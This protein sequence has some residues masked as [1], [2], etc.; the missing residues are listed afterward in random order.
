MLLLA[1]LLFAQAVLAVEM[2]APPPE[3]LRLQ[4]QA[5]PKFQFAGYYAAR[6]QG[7]Y[8]EEGLDVEIQPR[9]SGQDVLQQVMSGQADFGIGDAGLVAHAANGQPLTLVA[10]V[11][12]H[13][14]QALFSKRSLAISAPNAILGK[15]IMFDA[16]SNDF[17]P[18]RMLFS[19]LKMQPEQ[20]QSVLGGSIDELLRGKSDLIV[21]NSTE[22]PHEFKKR[23]IA[24]NSIQPLDYGIDVY[25]E[26]LF[27]SLQQIQAHPER[28]ERFRRAS[29]KGWHYALEHSE[30]LVRLL[31]QQYHSD[32][33]MKALR[34]EAEVMRRLMLPEQ[35]PLGHLDS[36]RVKAIAEQ[37]QTLNMAPALS[38]SQ[39]QQLVYYPR[40]PQ[41]PSGDQPRQA[42]PSAQPSWIGT[43]PAKILD[44]AEFVVIAMVIF[45]LFGYWIYRLHR[46]VVA[47]RLSEAELALLYTNM[48]L[49]F[50]LHQVQR[51][52]T[53]NIVDYF[54]LQINPAFEAMTG[55]SRENVCGKSARQLQANS[56]SH[57]LKHFADVEA[58]G[59]AK[60]FESHAQASNRW[61]ITD[62]YQAGK[63]RFVVLLH[64]IS[65]RKYAEQKLQLS[66]RVFSD[67]HEGIIIT[68]VH[69]GI[70]DVNAAFSSIT[71]YSRE[72]VLG[73]NPGL[74]KSGRHDNDFYQA[75]WADLLDHGHWQGEVWNRRKN[76]EHFVELLTISALR[77]DSEQVINYLGI[78]SD[79]TESKKQQQRLEQLA[80]YD[81]LTQLPNRAL[82]ADRFNQAIANSRR[83]DEL[84]AVCYLDLDGFKR[85]NDSFGHEVGDELLIEVAKRIKLKLRESDTVC[86]LGGDEFVMLLE[87]LQS[88]QQ[89]EETLKRI[90]AALAEVFIA[91]SKEIYISASSGVTLYPLDKDEPDI[92]LRHAD[93][94]M[95][96][97]KQAGRNCYRFHHYPSFGHSYSKSSNVVRPE[98]EGDEI[99]LALQYE[100][101]CL[102]YQPKVNLKTGEVIGVEALIRWQHPQRG[103]L[104]PGEFLPQLESTTLELDI[105]NWLVRQAFQQLQNWLNQGVKLQ[106]SI[107]VSPRFLQWQNFLPMLDSVLNEYPD[108]SSRQI[109]LEVLESSVL[110]DM[111]S[112]A[113]VLR[114][115]Y[116]QFGVSS[117]LDDFGTGYSSL[118]HLRHLTINTVKIDQ[119]FVRNMID[120]PDDQS[121][122][123]SVIGLAKAFKREVI[124]EG[125]ESLDDGIFL[126]NLGCS[127]AQGNIIAPPM[128]GSQVLDWVRDYRNP[129]VWQQQAESK[130]NAG[131]RQL[132]LLRIQQQHWLQ[133]IQSIYQKRDNASRWPILIPKKTHL[134]KWLLRS[135]L[136]KTIDPLPL[137]QLQQSLAQ[138]CKLA[139]LLR[140]HQQEHHNEQ[141]VAVLARLTQASERTDLLLRQ[142][143]QSTA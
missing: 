88:P 68:D 8:A 47:L 22:L 44:I 20:Y 121:I 29:L 11:L 30:E 101:F 73:M 58:D 59:K 70:I 120:N 21:G 117:A 77:D 89:C 19:K 40:Q 79:I 7:F 133:R 78:F 66:A 118:T 63:D 122:V 31:R 16:T 6:Q 17:S 104:M 26:L 123:E 124:A 109:E 9:D 137:Q 18:V 27:C 87:K 49:G 15:R 50:A 98:D 94:A 1:M 23:G 126:I 112:V 53:G 42:N 39:L 2:A 60:H 141:A 14:G 82:F 67:A 65:E 108:V 28:V 64:D 36:Q 33:P 139:M 134:G 113:E 103:L 51:D 116:Y 129:P 32:S 96:A 55:I 138:Q 142:L 85:V 99:Q 45:L 24:F 143:E 107:N 52:H 46:E 75:M 130:R 136:N 56:E 43:L 92:L 57:W 110:D 34:H 115:C 95:Y 13:S 90:H 76:G 41:L 100:Q 3:K 62:C 48:S 4:L 54:Y 125:V 114:Q 69:A 111:E 38:P 140:Q 132:L 80:H 97:A 128:P 10:A 83:T 81:P 71:G 86:R 12:Q 37:Y 61:Y 5:L 102:H 74:L 127:L 105:S 135:Q 93:Q 84:L 131:Q 35:V 72:E 106:I 25:A 91:G 119:S